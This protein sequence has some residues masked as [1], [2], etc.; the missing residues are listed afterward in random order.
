M[1]KLTHRNN[2]AANNHSLYQTNLLT[3]QTQLLTDI[4][5]N[6]GNIKL[7]ADSVNLNVDTLEALQTTA[8]TTLAA[9]LVDTDAADSSLNTIEAQSVFT[10]SRLNNIQNK[11]S[12]NVDGTGDTLGQIAADIASKAG[13]IKTSVEL[14]D[15]AVSGNELQ[16][17]VVAALPAGTNKIG[18][19][20]LKANEAVDGSGTE[21]HLVTD[22]NGF[23]QVEDKSLTIVAPTVNLAESTSLQRVNLAL[24]DSGN[25]TT[26]TAKC[27]AAGELLVN[28]AGT[29]TAN[30]SAV[31]NAVL[32][33]IAS[34]AG[35]IK[36][37]VEL[38]DNAIS[39]SEMQVDVVA[40]LPVGANK[41]GAVAMRANEAADGSGTERHLLCD[42]A[43][44]L[45]VD[46]ISAPTTAV[47]GTVTANLSAT[48]NAVLDDIASK[49]GSIKT[50]VELIDNAI[51]GSEMQVDV[52][53]ALPAGTNKIGAVALKANEAA[54]GSG[55]ERH[56]VTD[57][58]GFLQVEDKSLTI[59]APTVN[60]AESTTLQR[61]NLALHDSG[62][63]TT[64]TAKCNSSGEMKVEA[65]GTVTA[66]LSAV[67][68][69]VLDD[70]ASKAG[71]IKTAVEVIDDVVKAED[72][73]HSSGDKGVM[74]L[75][76]R[77]STQA[78]FGADGDYVPLSINDSGQL[79]VLAPINGRATSAKQDVIEAT[80]TNLETSLAALDNAVDGNYLNVNANIAGT[81]VD[82][83]SGNKSAATQRVVVATDDVNLS[84]IKTAV[85]ALNTRDSLTTTLIID[86]QTISAGGGTHTTGS[87]EVT[88]I[89]PDGKLKFLV[90]ISG[91][92]V[93][94]AAS[95]IL[96]SA[97]DTNF[98]GVD[99]S[100]LGG[101][102][103]TSGVGQMVTCSFVPKHFK[104]VITNSSLGSAATVTVHMFN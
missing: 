53:A 81:D 31:D 103:A 78:N 65:S 24:H 38:I 86:G 50:S 5:T 35:S 11:I 18:A 69:A 51:S 13:S 45:Q 62:N 77:Q 32:D 3:D 73:A 43:G 99:L 88:N 40:A 10:A 29:V 72:A 56:L 91:V 16:V 37:S 68:N 44:H 79:R 12:A 87:F 6:T 28:A 49:A 74:F 19:V 83:N 2:R 61:V 25:S 22:A 46:V 17:D 34:K 102:N 23:L 14:I 96:V 41:I 48:D 59:V 54:D 93:G 82:A 97:D 55:T 94:E 1:S 104:Y 52:V 98:F 21:R 33:D 64:R 30:L 90:R 42:S 20:A 92:G 84:A 4:K 76:V 71:S 8:N 7:T 67:D 75:G 89:P 66:N 26:R 63:S 15:N 47:T 27:N 36:T 9:I 58:N 95:N 60:L 80:L 57:A 70:I 101:G 85:E 100:F 39:G